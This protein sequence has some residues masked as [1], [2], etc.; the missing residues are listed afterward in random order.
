MSMKV[1][2][3]I[4]FIEIFCA[5]L[6]MTTVLPFFVMRTRLKKQRMTEKLLMSF[7]VGN[8]YLM[9]LVFLLQ[10]L[11]I[12]NRWTLLL[13]TI[14][15]AL[16]VWIR[17]NRVHVLEKTG[18]AWETLRKLATGHVSSKRVVYQL[19]K[20]IFKRIQWLMRYLGKA[21]LKHPLEWLLVLGVMCVAAWFYGVGK[22]EVYGYTASDTPVHLYWINGM[23]ENN[24]FIDGVYP[25]GYHCIIYYL[26]A[27]FQ[28]DS[29]VLMCLFSLVQ[30]I[31]IHLVLLAFLRLC[32]KSRYVSYAVVLVYILG[33]FLQPSSYLRFFAVLPQ[34]YGMLFI[35]PSAYFAFRFFAARKREIQGKKTRLSSAWCLTFFAM[36]FGMTLAVHFYD[37]MIAGLF[38]VGIAL[39]YIGWFVRGKYFWRVVLACFLGVF[40]AVL[41]MAAAFISGTPLQGSLGWGMSVIQGDSAQNAENTDGGAVQQ[42]SGNATVYYYDSDGNLLQENTVDTEEALEKT[43]HL[44]VPLTQKLL[45][46]WNKLTM[47]IKDAVLNEAQAWYVMVV[48]GAFALLFVFGFLF[49]LLKKRQYGAM[50]MSMGWFMVLLWILQTA[51]ELGI[52]ELMDGSR[53]RIYFAY[54]LP[55]VFG[56]VSDAAIRLIVFPRSWRV[57]RDLISFACIGAIV[58]LLWDG[59]HR[60]P[61]VENT[62]LVTNEALACLT[63]IIKEEEDNTWTIVS[64]ND[65]TQMGLYHG[66]HYE[67]ISFL[68]EMEYKNAKPGEELNIKIPTDSVYVFVEKVPLDYTEHYERSGQSVSVEGAEKELPNVGG[69]AMYKGEYRWILMSRLYYWAKEFERLYPTNVSV[70]CETE[71]F[72]CYKIKQNPYRLFNFAID[73]RYN[74]EE[75]GGE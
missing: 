54:M 67:L 11:H 43:R 75:T 21:F 55:V 17:L 28:I 32:C 58:L 46:V 30:T 26:H 25:F 20:R 51:K 6:G 60:K 35:L 2:M 40:S 34:E 33:N 8:F 61:L 56:F 7:L 59:N 53:C 1:F 16:A 37:T 24:I 12:S 57:V 13:G 18:N 23:E 15:P 31:A 22:L 9:N 45:R 14:I 50:L 5:Y 71:D 19:G 52:P 68:R 73:Y 63:S 29:Y 3:I 10:L 72:V 38:C 47:T 66:Y 39:G 64:A 41:P 42:I 48:V 62:A 4:K 70:Y 27:V 74:L 49:F 65:E 36:S 69:I 44:D